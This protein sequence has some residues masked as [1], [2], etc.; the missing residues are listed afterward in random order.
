ME[1]FDRLK[2][3]Y[4]LAPIHK[5]YEGIELELEEQKS[6]ITLPIDERY[7]H[8]G[9]AIHGSVYFKLLDD[10]A[11]FA[12]QTLVTD[13]FLVTTSFNINLLKPI[14]E[15]KIY[16]AGEVDYTSDKLFKGYANLY[17]ERGRL[18]GTGRGQFVK[19]KLKLETVK[20]Y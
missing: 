11:Y 10:A 4:A 1:H 5:F 15:G 20:D 3:M 7:F 18:C 12:C 8:G 13:F 17:D 2:K 9:M 19:S 6:K 14:I 16:A